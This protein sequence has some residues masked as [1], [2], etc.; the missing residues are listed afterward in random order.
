M[1]LDF[2]THVAQ[3]LPAHWPHRDNSTFIS[4][5]GYQFHVQRMDA[6][7][8]TDASVTD[9][10]ATQ[11]APSLLLHGTGASTH[12]WAGVMPLLAEHRPVIAIDLPGHGFTQTPANADLSIPG[13]ARAIRNLLD[14]MRVE[15][16]VGIGHSAGAAILAELSVSKLLKLD[17]LVSINGAMLPLN[18]VAGIVFSPLAK[19]SAGI[20]WLPGLFARRASDRQ[21]VLRLINSTGSRLEEPGLRC[22]ETLLSNERHVAGVLKMMASWQLES[23]MPSL[24]NLQASTLLLA[25]DADKTIPLRDAYRLRTLLPNATLKVIKG[26]GHL[27][28][29]EDPARILACIE[30]HEDMEDIKG[31]EE[32]QHAPEDHRKRA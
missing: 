28:H 17:R 27:A 31:M 25:A 10:N 12:S 14:E 7:S 1:A 5:A 26:L 18:G 13:V 3:T 23:L 21:Q 15:P 16:S 6:H 29:E 32:R 20:G 19:L 22:Y 4:A 24:S 9:P 30:E 8:E 2:Q 11:P